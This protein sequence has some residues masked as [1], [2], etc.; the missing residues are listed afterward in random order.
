MENK[1]TQKPKITEQQQTAASYI[2]T[3]YQNVQMLTHN[4]ANYHSLLLTMENEYSGDIKK[5]PDE[6]KNKVLEF[7]NTVRY[8]AIMTFTSLNVIQ[9][10]LNVQRSPDLDKLHEKIENTLILDRKVLKDYVNAI[11]LE[12]SANI[13]KDL[14]NTSEAII[15]NLFA[16]E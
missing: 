4:Y 15:N 5:M 6:H 12:L 3:F 13:M 2:L 8:H 9:K 14:L 10:R 16:N 1:Q 11:H 7:S